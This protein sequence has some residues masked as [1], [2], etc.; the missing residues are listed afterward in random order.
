MKLFSTTCIALAAAKKNGGR[1]FQGESDEL[2]YSNDASFVTGDFMPDRFPI[3]GQENYEEQLDSHN[4]FA[5]RYYNSEFDGV[6]NQARYMSMFSKISTMVEKAVDKCVDWDTFVAPEVNED[7][8][9]FDR[10]RRAPSGIGPLTGTI[11]N[12]AHIVR[13]LVIPAVVESGDKQSKKCLKQGY[14]LLRKMDRHRL[15]TLWG[16]CKD[17]DREAIPCTW[18][19]EANDG[20]P[21]RNLEDG[22]NAQWDSFTASFHTSLRNDRVCDNGDSRF[23]DKISCEM[24]EINVVNA[25]YGRRSTKICKGIFPLLFPSFHYFQVTTALQISAPDSEAL[26]ILSAKCRPTAMARLNASSKRLKNTPA[27]ILAP[28]RTNTSKL[29]TNALS[30]KAPQKDPACKMILFPQ[31]NGE[32]LNDFHVSLDKIRLN[33]VQSTNSALLM[34]YKKGLFTLKCP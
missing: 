1:N 25:W 11:T 23:D 21:W 7:G 30:Q 12:L 32:N 18:A 27:V 9:A 3:T 31:I 28:A 10:D 6:K 5:E 2:L 22:T 15:Y 8:S 4:N 17:I 20:K 14:K 34:F 33:F 19:Y 16:Y 29:P 26:S 24:G 13:Q